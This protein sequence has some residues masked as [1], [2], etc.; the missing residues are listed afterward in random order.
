MALGLAAFA[1][2][3]AVVMLIVEPVPI[4]PGGVL[5]EQ[6]QDAETAL[7]LTAFLLVL[8]LALTVAPRIADAIA[9]GPNAAALPALS[10]LLLAALAAAILLVRLSGLL[11][12][13]GGMGALLG[14]VAIWWVGAAALLA[15]ALGEQRSPLLSRA[16]G[17]SPQAWGLAGALLLGTLL[18]VTRLRSLSLPVLAL[19]AVVAVAVLVVVVRGTRLPRL[20]RRWGLAADAL[21]AGLLL[22]AVPDLVIFRPEEAGS[23]AA[24][25]YETGIIQFHH[26]FLLGPANQVLGGDAMLVD[27]ASQYGV[28]SIYLL[29]GWFQ[30][31]PIGYGTFGF[32]DG[33]LTALFYVAGYCVLRVAGAS[34]PLAAS[35]LAIAVVA[36]VFNLV[37]PVGA[38]PQQGPLRFGLPIVLILAAAAGARWPRRAG[39]AQMASFLILGLASIWAFE[40]LAFT[41]ATFAAIAAMQ[42]YLRQAGERRRWLLRQAIL[43]AAAC[44][45]AH[46][47]LAAAT[48]LFAGQLPEWG[49]YLAYLDAFLFGQLGDLTYDFAQWSPG[50]AVGAAYLASAAALVLLAR[51]R[52]G[53]VAEERVALL[54]LAGTTAYGIALFSYFVNRSSD[55]ILPYVSLPALLSAAL[56]LSLL[57]RNR[58]GLPREAREGGLAFALAV[59][60]L[61][62]SVA[63]SSLGPRFPQ[64]ALAHAFPRGNS[65]RDALE[66]LWDPP[67]LDPSAPAGE[68]LLA[69]H[70]PG[71]RRTVV[72]VSPD[73]GTEILL[74]SERANRLPLG[75]PWED[76]FVIS[77]RLPGLRDAIAGLAPGDRMLVD[78]EALR[79]LAG[80]RANPSRNPL[81]EA[82]STRPLAPLQRWAL[83]EVDE[84]FRLRAIARDDL[85]FTVLELRAPDGGAAAG[86]TTGG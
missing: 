20:P 49:Q 28:G 21:I 3:M 65:F 11:D 47:L 31:A 25:A 33:V 76:S 22:L 79:T 50:L 45:A 68:L 32:L 19:G 64:S 37:Y 8:P 58:E 82:G 52:S 6:R 77:E 81:G 2:V 72:L 7:F 24:I 60:V 86:R 69:R 1:V 56:W 38:L 54:A 57:L 55:H 41:A 53:F 4:V 39:A 29:A 85:G 63:G 13:G 23:A 48:L 71:E 18:T 12:W 14:A 46:L 34:R 66:R 36:L 75:N 62:L 17:I 83:R 5:G 16:A 73:L 43:G 44:A 35:A 40:A 51:R 10:G 70:M 59:A 61:V 84:R 78:R 30:L 15:S 67:P 42:A 80:Q 27:T 26:D 9:A 74:R